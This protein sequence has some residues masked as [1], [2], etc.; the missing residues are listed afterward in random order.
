MLKNAQSALVTGA[1]GFI[2]SALV[3][4]LS[5]EGVRV[6]CLVR[7]NSPGCSRVRDLPGVEVLEI[8]TYD[9]A[10]LSQKLSRI[11]ADAVFNLASAGVVPEERDPHML[12]A[13]ISPSLSVSSLPPRSGACA[14]SFI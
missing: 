12:I 14:D 1:T 5:N 6:F 10:V 11:Q 4:R 9:S 2:G 8:E 7:P 13:E 3:R